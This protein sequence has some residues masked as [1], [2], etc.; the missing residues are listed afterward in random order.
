MT[1][2]IYV[3]DT[4][5]A[6]HVRVPK[7]VD[8]RLLG[9]G[10]S[11]S[12]GARLVHQIISMIKWIRTRRFSIKRS[13]SLDPHP[14]SCY[15]PPSVKFRAC[16]S[17]GRFRACASGFE[18]QKHLSRGENVECGFGIQVQDSGSGGVKSALV[19]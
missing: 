7:K 15:A 9:Q 10:N 12:H 14:M 18:V 11:N 16:V 2:S 13:L 5:Y 8:I 3:Y 4:S 6:V 1:R 19:V 17:H